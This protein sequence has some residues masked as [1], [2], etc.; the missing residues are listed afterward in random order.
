MD[1]KN[2]KKLLSNYD[3]KVLKEELYKLF[4]DIQNAWMEFDY[5]KLR[6]LC[7]DE[8]YNTYKAQLYVL[9][10]K[11]QKNI[12]HDY[13][14]ITS[15]IDSIK[16]ENDTVTIIVF[17]EVELYDYVVNDKNKVVRGTKKNTLINNYEMTFVRGIGTST[18]TCPNC[19]KELDD[20]PSSVCKYCGSNIVKNSNKFVLSRK[21]NINK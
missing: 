9:K 7:T 1:D 12:M 11:K 5:E 15:K 21:K 13:K 16:E 3:S 19:G 6:S 8:L 14:L 4:V 20:S 10:A 18:T 2:I 17:M